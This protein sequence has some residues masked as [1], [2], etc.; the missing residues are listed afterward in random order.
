MSGDTVI[1]EAL[2]F[3]NDNKFA[4]VYSGSITDAA[5]SAANTTLL[6]IK[7]QSEYLDAKLTITNDEAST[8][9]LFIEGFFNGVKVIDI[10]SDNSS[11][12]NPLITPYQMLIPPFTE[13]ELKAGANS[14]VDFTA[15]LIAKVG[16]AQR[17]G[18]L[19]E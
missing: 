13:F 10:I 15:W 18:N 17:V 4:Y 16:M 19:D 3:T 1:G 11:I 2:Q 14:T 5:S 8:A 7:T 12:N 9:A 6:L